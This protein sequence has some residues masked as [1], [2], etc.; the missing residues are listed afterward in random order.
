MTTLH[1]LVLLVQ[2]MSVLISTNFRHKK[3]KNY[4]YLSLLQH[5]IVFK[6]TY[7]LTFKKVLL[8]RRI[9]PSDY[10]GSINMSLPATLAGI[11]YLSAM[12]AHYADIMVPSHA[13][14][15]AGTYDLDRDHIVSSRV[16]GLITVH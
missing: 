12:L 1:S 3:N 6:S 4:N 7:L 14:L 9:L 5:L 13:F 8:H 10:S 16:P 11:K 15:A 2:I